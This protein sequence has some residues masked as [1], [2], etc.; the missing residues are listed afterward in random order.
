MNYQLII[1]YINRKYHKEV[2]KS[3]MYDKIAEWRHWLEGDV[4]NFHEFHKKM[5]LNDNES[6]VK[7]HR[8]KTNMLLKG[9]EDWASILLNEKT[10][11]VIED[12]KS[13]E[14][15]MG[16]DEISGVFGDNDFWRNAN[17]LVATS[18]WSGTGAF[19]IYVRKMQR[20]DEE[21]ENNGNLEGGQ[22]IGINYL[23]AEQII[24]ISYDNSIMKEAAFVS[25][26]V[27]NG[28]EVSLIS[29][30][31]LN[32]KGTYDIERRPFLSLKELENV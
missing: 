6:K 2:K 16:Q 4:R 1:D 24:P 17:E 10:R 7:L 25:E 9:A 23:S 29:V 3:I 11:I 30:H 27:L 19:E 22:S 8:N 31:V 12:K 18:R 5:D 21:G 26:R 28:K 15:V 14:F 20:N 32:E 13:N